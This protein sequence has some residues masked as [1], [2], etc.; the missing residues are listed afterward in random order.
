[1]QPGYQVRTSANAPMG[2]G[3]GPMAIANWSCQQHKNLRFSKGHGGTF[4]LKATRDIKPG[5]DL[6]AGY[7]THKEMT[8]L[9][10]NPGALRTRGA[11]RAL[12]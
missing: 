9:V 10:C 5:E 3:R 11:R 4:N 8:C 6:Y 12:R 7:S 2:T 1:M